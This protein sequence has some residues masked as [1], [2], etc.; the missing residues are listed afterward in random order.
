MRVSLSGAQGCP[1]NGVKADAPLGK[2]GAR[3][4]PSQHQV[5]AGGQETPPVIL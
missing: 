3:T 4:A 5:P 1:P 2:H